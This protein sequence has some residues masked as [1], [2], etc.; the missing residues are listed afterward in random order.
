MF[1]LLAF[2]TQA[3]RLPDWATDRE[4]YKKP[5][6]QTSIRFAI[7]SY[8]NVFRVCYVPIPCTFTVAHRV[9]LEFEEV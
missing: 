2:Y 7:Y 8:N 9:R 4:A 5:K 3:A 1:A 6:V